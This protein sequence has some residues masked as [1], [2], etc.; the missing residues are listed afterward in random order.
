M[1]ITATIISH[2]LTNI[3]VDNVIMHLTEYWKQKKGKLDM[4]NLMIIT[5]ICHF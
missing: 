5:Y 4:L 1:D 3:T 2:G